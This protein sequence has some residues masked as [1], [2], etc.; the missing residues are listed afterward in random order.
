VR[1]VIEVK[2][3]PGT[4]FSVKSYLAVCDDGTVWMYTDSNDDWIQLPAI[5]E[6]KKE[7]FLERFH[8]FIFGCFYG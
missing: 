1:K 5:P 2:Q 8:K 3:V 6:H 7:G 4:L